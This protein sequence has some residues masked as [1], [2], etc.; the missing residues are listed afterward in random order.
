MAQKTCH[1]YEQSSLPY[2]W[3]IGWL[4][5]QWSR[6]LLEFDKTLNSRSI[7]ET[8]DSSLNLQGISRS[9]NVLTFTSKTI[10]P[11]VS[12]YKKNR[13]C[14]WLN[15]FHDTVRK[16][17]DVRVIQ[18]IRCC[19]ENKTTSQAMDPSTGEVVESAEDHVGEAF[20]KVN[21]VNQLVRGRATFKTSPSAYNSK[22]NWSGDETQRDVWITLFSNWWNW[23]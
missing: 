3:S 16:E 12:L 17:N 21:H 10:L 2:F 18:F 9:V 7:T 6:D 15:R 19:E 5:V 4:N 20:G 11:D 22:Y 8:V 13:T 14:G 1:L 23:D